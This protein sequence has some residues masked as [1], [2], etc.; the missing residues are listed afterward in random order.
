[1]SIQNGSLF[2]K[3]L[4]NKYHPS[5]QDSLIKL[6]P[7]ERQKELE[8]YASVA[9]N[10]PLS[11]LPSSGN[12]IEYIHYSW[13]ETPL[14]TVPQNLKSCIIAAL[15]H[16]QKEKISQRAE[17]TP[18][19]EEQMHY[20]ESVKNFLLNYLY[21]A[22][23]D[24]NVLPRDL[25]P[26][27]PLSPLLT[28]TKTEIVDIIDLLAMHDLAEEIRHIVDKKLIQAIVV[29]LTLLQQKYLKIC[30]HQKSKIPIPPLNIREA[31]KDKKAFIIALHRR[32]L[33]RLSIAISGLPA[34]FLW[35]IT[36]T[37]DTGRGKILMSQYQPTEIATTT[38]VTQLQVLQI[39]QFIKGK[40]TT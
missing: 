18:P 2:F 5:K 11:L 19:S 38:A 20:A 31:H 33:K 39:I 30:L 1:M 21:K 16:E 13:L 7:E 17:V 32:G 6:L 36:H 22:W 10:N 37:V 28:C 24:K 34:D 23:D 15:P 25:L 12:W 35:H 4:L 3:L 29:N 8:S 26:D 40:A 9:A 14:S 27:C